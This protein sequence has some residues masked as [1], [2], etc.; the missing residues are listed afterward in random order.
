MDK[1]L[2]QIVN[3][4]NSFLETKLDNYGEELWKWMEDRFQI[5]AA[6]QHPKIWMNNVTIKSTGEGTID[7]A[8]KFFID[9]VKLKQ[10]QRGNRIR[11]E[12]HGEIVS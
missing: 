4:N 6:W 8:V 2:Q 9:N 10:C 12:V 1:F 3:A 5:Y 11:S 7:L